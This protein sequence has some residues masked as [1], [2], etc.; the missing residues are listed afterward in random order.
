MISVTAGR[1]LPPSLTV[2]HETLQ[3][4]EIVYDVASAYEN[5]VKKFATFT[6]GDGRIITA[7]AVSFQEGSDAC[8]A[9]TVTVLSTLRSIPVSQATPVP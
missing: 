6:G 1:G 8:L 9:A 5:G 7:F 2:E 3:M 4:G